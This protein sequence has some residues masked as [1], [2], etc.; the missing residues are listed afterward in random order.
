MEDFSFNDLLSAAAGYFGDKTKADAQVQLAKAN[1]GA[2][3]QQA[4]T[5]QAQA[6]AAQ[7]S[8][9]IPG[10]SNGLVVGAGIGLVA[11]GLVVT[12]F[13]TRKS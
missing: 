2:A 5:A 11:L 10:V 3:A 4:N 6:T 12:V 8:Q 1:L 13:A 9:W 7:T